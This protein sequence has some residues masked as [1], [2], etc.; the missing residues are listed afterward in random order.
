MSQYLA[1]L[2]SLNS[3]AGDAA[4]MITKMCHSSEC[5]AI[6]LGFK[7][8]RCKEVKTF[9]LSLEHCICV[10]KCRFS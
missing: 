2:V 3:T 9:L 1:V 8:I 6:C 5:K 7:Y 10:N 4:R